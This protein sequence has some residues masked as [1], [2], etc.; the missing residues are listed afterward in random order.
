[1]KRLILLVI[2]IPVWLL[3]VKMNNSLTDLPLN[4]QERMSAVITSEEVKPFMLG[5]HSVVAD[6]IWIRTMLYFGGNYQAGDMKWLKS[7]IAS[8]VTLNPEF[9][10]PY[11]FAGLMVPDQT[12]DYEFARDILYHGIGRVND[13]EERLMFYLAYLNYT[14]YKDFEQAGDLLSYA[15]TAD[16][17]PPF[18]GRFA[19]SLYRDAGNVDYGMRFLYS[20][21]ET[22]ESPQIKEQMEIKLRELAEEHGIDLKEGL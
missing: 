2:L 13:G 14:H 3:S 16:Y 18:W 17:A 20:I 6:Y 7:M 21:Y 1:M 8:V 9:F 4:R 11:E 15:A 5:Y 22:T 12:G 19:A 10:P